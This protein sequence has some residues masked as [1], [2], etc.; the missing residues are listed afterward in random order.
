MNDN[1]LPKNTLFKIIYKHTLIDELPH[2]YKT[3][4]HTHIYIYL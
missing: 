4:T 3:H 1:L 2:I